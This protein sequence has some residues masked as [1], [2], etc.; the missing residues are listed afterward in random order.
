M[1]AAVAVTAERLSMLFVT[2]TSPAGGATNDGVG[3]NAR[4]LI[5][6]VFPCRN[7]ILLNY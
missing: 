7:D 1:K 6:Y 3:T 4:T 2:S 5:K